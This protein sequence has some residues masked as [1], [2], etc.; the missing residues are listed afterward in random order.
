M[1]INERDYR[2]F[3]PRAVAV[4]AQ[5]LAE[6]GASGFKFDDQVWPPDSWLVRLLGGVKQVM[7]DSM[8]HALFV[9]E[10]VIDIEDEEDE[11][12]ESDE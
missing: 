5:Q 8:F 10:R 3:R 12:E 1:K 7:S 6:E 2:R 9:P 11:E 4:E